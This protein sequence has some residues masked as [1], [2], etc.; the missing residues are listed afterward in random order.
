MSLSRL[1]CDL[2]SE[3][4]PSPNFG[5]RRGGRRPDA[6]VLHYTGMTSEDG[7]L[8]WLCDPQSQVSCHYFVRANG[9]IAQLVAEDDRA[10]HAG[11][12]SWRGERDLN[13]ASIGIEIANPGH[14]YGLPPYPDAQITAAIGLCRDLTRRLSIAPERLLAHS[15]IAPGRKRDPGERFPWRRLYENGLGIWTAPAP[16]A[17]GPS[18]GRGATGEEVVRLRAMLARVGYACPSG[19]VFDASAEAVVRAFQRRFRPDRVDGIADLS[20]MT[21]LR[22]LLRKYPPAPDSPS[23]A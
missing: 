1:Q 21:T 6:I 13:S 2:A 12:S 20:T 14:A 19:A 10:W 4:R 22:D 8:S 18:L 23:Q 5:D 17:D 11:V 7:A 16:V 15:D 9:A 3:L